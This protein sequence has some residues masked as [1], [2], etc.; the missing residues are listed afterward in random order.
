MFLG[1]YEITKTENAFFCWPWKD[2]KLLKEIEDIKAR[3]DALEK[4]LLEEQKK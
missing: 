1:D 2:E 4:L 3:L